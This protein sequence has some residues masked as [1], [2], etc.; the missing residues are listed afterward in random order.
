[1]NGSIENYI[2]SKG[3]TFKYRNGE[4]A[5]DECPLSGCGP[6]HFYISDK[7]EVFYCQKCNERGHLLSLKKRLGDLPRVAHVSQY[8]KP[9]TPSKTIDPSIV[10]GYHKALLENPETLAYL[11]DRRGFTLET[12]KKFKL[13]LHDDAIT[14]PHFQEGICANVKFRH[15]KSGDT[16]Y[17]REEGYPSVLFN[18]DSAIKYQDSVIVCEGEFDCMGFDQMGFPN[19][20]SVTCGAGTFHDEWVDDFDGFGQIYLSYDMD[21]EGR[22]GVEKVA[23]KLGRYRCLDVLLPLKDANECLQAGF[24]NREITEILAQAK[25]FTI[26]TIKSPEEFSDEIRA[27][28]AG[29]GTRAIKTG[30]TE[31]DKTLNGFRQSELTIL[32]GETGSGKSTHA[33]NLGY[34]LARDRHPVLIASFEQKPATLIGKM[35]QMKTGK[36][37]AELSSKELEKAL[38]HMNSLPIHFVDVYGEIGLDQLK[39]AIFYARRRFGVELVVIDHLHF[40]LKF[41][42]DHE[43]QAIDVA[44]RDIKSWAMELGTHTVLVVHPT[45]LQD[46]NQVVRLN[47]LKGS[48]G[49]KQIPDNVL[50]LWRP[51]GH[52][53]SN[54]VLL[55]VLK[56][57]DDSGDEGKV[58]LT[59]DKRSQSYEDAGL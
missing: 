47:D 10:E 48:S 30:W 5:L 26:K 46:D 50:S 11:T 44:L 27:R 33:T 37:L 55:Y 28:H 58:I 23:D 14:I 38:A 19:V 2:D 24:S 40:F 13:G 51:R 53:A 21:E 34:R 32:T 59:F 17:S 8:S 45:K 6:G 42:G 39:D 25:H 12:I 20:V 54:E 3:W 31:F 16:K 4:Y 15:R 52:N 35:I 41:S 9:S 22:K 43:R 29:N 1:M 18:I 56:C 36:P 57:R 7:K 49:L